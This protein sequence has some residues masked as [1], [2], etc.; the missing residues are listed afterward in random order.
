MK[1]R[2]EVEKLLKSMTR[3]PDLRTLAALEVTRG[4]G[5]GGGGGG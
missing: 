4:E 3:F 2:E 1:T 5:Y